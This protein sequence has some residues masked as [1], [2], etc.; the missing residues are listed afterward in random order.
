MHVEAAKHCQSKLDFKKREEKNKD[1]DRRTDQAKTTTWTRI[2]GKPERE[3][4]EGGK[5]REL[6]Q[7]K[8]SKDQKR[9]SQEALLSPYM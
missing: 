6:R 2:R 1:T 9:F 3:A 4:R 7:T 5:L 8:Q